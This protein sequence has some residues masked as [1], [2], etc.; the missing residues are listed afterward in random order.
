MGT[1]KPEKQHAAECAVAEKR[2]IEL[3]KLFEER[4]TILKT[5]GEEHEK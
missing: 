2:H 5:Q 1:S 4:F 3:K